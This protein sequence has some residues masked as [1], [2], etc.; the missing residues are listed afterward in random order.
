MRL[1]LKDARCSISLWVVFPC[2]RARQAIQEEMATAPKATSQA[3]VTAV[4]ANLVIASAKTVA[5]LFTR[6]SGMLSEAIHSFVDAANDSLLVY[7]EH[8]ADRPADETHPF[9]YGK[10]LY[11]WTLLVALFL[12]ILGGCFSLYEGTHR[13]LHPEP[14]RHAF[15]SY[16]TLGLAFCFEG[17]SFL[18]GL[19]EFR[20]KEGVS[21][22][23]RAIHQSKDPTTFTVIY[24]DAAALLGLLIALGGTLCAQLLGWT[25]AD[26]ISS[27]CIGA[28][29]LV[30]AVL[31]VSESK[32]LLIGEGLDV[33]E[34]R[35]VRELAL[36]QSGVVSVGYPMT[37]YFGPE[38]VLLTMNVR[39]AQNLN[40]DGIELTVDAVERAIRSQFPHIQHIYL[41]AES[42]GSDSR[43][44]PARL[45]QP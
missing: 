1:E 17:Y 16:V 35:E 40:R 5:F 9:G 6:S 30:V 18:V 37:M 12:F 25:R 39:F 3:A 34:L 31:L 21:V 8:R 27:L 14:L 43:F 13:L 4:L 26:G 28:L 2:L 36:A 20:E 33:K 22:S 23:F 7:G 10:E 19:R 41:E 45:P 32:A 15:W 42:L 44:D 38:N 24:E 29:L 11:F